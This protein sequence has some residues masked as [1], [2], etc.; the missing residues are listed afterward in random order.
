MSVTIGCHRLPCSIIALWCVAHFKRSKR[1]HIYLLN[2]H[3]DQTTPM[4]QRTLVTLAALTLG[5]A[6]FTF[7]LFKNKSH[8]PEPTDTTTKDT[9]TN[10]TT[11]KVAISEGKGTPPQA[12]PVPL[13]V[14]TQASPARPAAGNDRDDP[15]PP[16]SPDSAT[17]HSCPNS[18]SA[19]SASV[20]FGATENTVTAD[21]P[22]RY[23]GK[24]VPKRKLSTTMQER[25]AQF[26]RT[27]S[28]DI[29]DLPSP[30][31]F[32][33]RGSSTLDKENASDSIPLPS[34]DN[35]AAPPTPPPIKKRYDPTAARLANSARRETIHFAAGCFWSVELVFQRAVG[36]WSTT[37]GYTQ[38][39]TED[40]SY[41]DVKGGKSGHVEC[42]AVVYDPALT[43]LEKLL[44]VFWGKHDAT[45]K[46]KQ[47]NDKGS[48]YRSGIYFFNDA[49]REV[50]LASIAAEKA[51]LDKPWHKI[52]TELKEAGA[53]Y[54]AEDYHQ[55][56][57]S[58]KGGRHGKK[59]SAMKGCTDPIRCYG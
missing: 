8:P 9:T 26:S 30:E 10:D 55:M 25:V 6:G 29:G 56:Y 41:E 17:F 33:R 24:P 59:Q 58:E 21:S 18:P 28:S 3:N 38:G 52:Q 44:S 23:L 36:V 57:L 40:P 47:G 48:Q 42:V 50:C 14:V 2:N 1:T 39:D 31:N 5:A 4:K 45:S 15:T 35:A 32:K 12:S 49:Q 46:N 27:T 34:F 19:P 11:T 43:S 54:K 7:M 51:K 53:F 37:V 16:D 13:T 22:T 20:D